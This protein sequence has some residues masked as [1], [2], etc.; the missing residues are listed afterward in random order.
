MPEKLLVGGGA[1]AL[2]HALRTQDEAVAARVEAL[3]REGKVLRFL[4]RI[5]VG[6][7][8][9]LAVTVGPE[10][11][12]LDHPAA[13][14][15][16]VEGYVAFTTARHPDRPLLV[17]GAGVGGASTAGALLAEIFRLSGG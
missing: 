12:G 13:R 16:G 14:L 9:E 11:V 4:S 17:Q 1:E 10:E 2:I 6:T 7:A 8:G 3:R 15:V 5:A